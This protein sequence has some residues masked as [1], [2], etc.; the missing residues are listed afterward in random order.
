[1]LSGGLSV[2]VWDASERV[3]VTPGPV[4]AANPA[5][6]FIESAWRLTRSTC[7]LPT[8]PVS[9]ATSSLRPATRFFRASTRCESPRTS[10]ARSV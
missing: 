10:E 7:L 8:A 9:A 2:V 4:T 1:M 6:L 5:G 3:T